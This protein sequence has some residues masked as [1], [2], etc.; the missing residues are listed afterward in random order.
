MLLCATAFKNEGSMAKR[1]VT[2][3]A[4]MNLR[5]K[6]SLRKKVEI[7]AK[8]N[9]VSLNQELVRRLERTFVDQGVE[10]LIQSTAMAVAQA[11]KNEINNGI[12]THL[13]GVI[14]EFNRIYGVLGRPDLMIEVK[15]E[16]DN[17]K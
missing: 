13:D 6:E 3:T 10:A 5:L 2:D 1:K 4:Q 17:G 11:V 15:G 7:E 14:D 9:G 8:K 16:R 12:V